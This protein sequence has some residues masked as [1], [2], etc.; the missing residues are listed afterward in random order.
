MMSLTFIQFLFAFSLMLLVHAQDQSGFISIDCGLAVNSSY[1]DV[2]TGIKYIS[3]ARFIDTGESKSV[4]PNQRNNY[5]QPYWNLRRF[6]EGT[7]NCYKIN[8][9]SGM[10]YL[11]RAGFFYGN[12]DGDNK[13]PVFELHLGANSWDTVRFKDA[14]TDKKKELIHTP[15]RNYIH[16]CLVDIGSGIPF[17]SAIELRPLPNETYQTQTGSLELVSRYDTGQMG[18]RRGYRF[19]FDIFDRVWSRAYNV[20]DSA[21]LS[22]PFTVNSSYHNK[23]RPPSDVMRTAA[24]PR[25]PNDPLNIRLPPSNDINAEYHIYM[26]FAEVEKLQPNQFRRFNITRNGDPFYGSVTPSYLYTATISSSKAFGGQQNNFSIFKAENSSLPPILNAFEIYKV[27]EFS[28]LDTDQDDV[29]AITNIKE[30]YKIRKNWQ[31]DPCSPQAYSWEGINCSY[32]AYEPLRRITT[33]NLSSNGLTGEIALSISNLAKIQTLD[34]SNN[35]LTGSIPEFLSQLPDLNFINLEKNKLTGSVPVGLIEKRKN[36]LLSLSLCQ[37]LNLSGNVPCK[38]K[39]NHKFIILEV[40]SISGISILLSIVAAIF[41]WGL[42]RRKQQGDVTNVKATIQL[43][44]MES[45]KRKFTYSE[46]LKITNN[47]ERILG[48]GGFGTVYHGYL[49][50]TQ[51][52]IKMLSPS[53]VQGFQ[54]FHAE[55]DLLMRVH[56]K[57]LTNLV[58]YCNDKTRVGLVYEYMCNGNLQEHLSDSSSNILT[59]K[60]RLRIAIDAAQ[61][62]EYLHYGCKPPIIHRDIK[63]TNILLNENL[64]AKLSDFGLSKIFPTNDGTH[65]MSHVGTPGYLDPEYYLSSRLNEKSDVYSFGIVLLEIITSRP[66]LSKLQE[67]IHISQWVGFMLEKGD[68]FS[69]VDSRRG[70]NFHANSVWKAVEIAMACVSPNVIDRPIMSEVIVELKESLATELALTKQSH[71]TESRISI[72]IMFNN[73]IAMLTPSIR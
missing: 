40:V 15:L 61:G 73:S 30:T 28:E 60:E 65:G 46:I 49:D 9:T 62:L 1:T 14:S 70:E 8:V 2:N 55:V 52:A 66:V 63:S 48:K 25:D 42:K 10:K 12:Y 51:V 35:N 7:R 59:W 11:I 3:D 44:S 57:N 23:Y 58:G 43:G 22:T 38:L 26:H 19:P 71:E 37:N 41:C 68:I 6:P 20:E 21:Q 31:G 54:Q 72:E 67:R 5:T 56:H 45:T 64:Q 27:K 17:I 47:F 24:T 36:G 50:K 16:V 34:L 39:K 33:L 69:I 32:H 53:A 13:L 18:T 4:W 29:V